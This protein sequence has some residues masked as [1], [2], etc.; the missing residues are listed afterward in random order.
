MCSRQ[1]DFST[2]ETISKQGSA[3]MRTAAHL[4]GEILASI[5]GV[6]VAFFAGGLFVT[7]AI[8]V[9][10]VGMVIAAALTL[11]ACM[12]AEERGGA[13]ARDRVAA[14]HRSALFSRGL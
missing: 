11:A 13:E 6:A 5:S 9:S 1:Q 10:I 4:W 12:I 7:G 8:A 2:A 3:V 14:I